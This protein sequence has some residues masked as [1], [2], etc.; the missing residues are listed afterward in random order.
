MTL[1]SYDSL[2]YFPHNSP[3]HFS[4]K[5][6]GILKVY[7]HWRV[8]LLE[9]HI[10]PRT[11]EPVY[12]CSNLTSGYIANGVYSTVLRYIGNPRKSN[13]FETPH[14]IDINSSEYD[15]QRSI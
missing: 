10:T 7:G 5:L 12:V 2:K 15:A 11:K 1:K 3:S 14:Y 8:A 13:V 6:P 9:I 4:V